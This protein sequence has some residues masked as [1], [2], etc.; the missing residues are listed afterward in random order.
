MENNVFFECCSGKAVGIVHKGIFLFVAML[1]GVFVSYAQD[2]INELDSLFFSKTEVRFSFVE[3]DLS[4]VAELAD[5]ISIDSRKQDSIYTAYANKEELAR[6]LEKGY[7]YTL[8]GA[9]LDTKSA[10][11]EEYMATTLEEMLGW[12]KYPT[13]DVYLQCMA[14]FANTYPSKCKVDTIGESVKGRLILALKISDNVLEDEDEPSF[15]YVSSMHGN[16]L[17]GCCMLLKLADTLLKNSDNDGAIQDLLATTQ[18]YINPLSNPD[19][20]YAGGNATV[21]NA[22]RYNANRVDL[23]RNFPD[24]WMTNNFTIQKENKLMMEYMKKKQFVLS[25]TLHGG[26]E[27]LNFP[28]DSYRSS[29]K[30]HADYEWW[31]SVCDRFVAECRAYDPT[32]Y[33]YDYVNGWVHGGD[34]YVV[35]KGKQDYVNYYLN[36]REITI[37]ISAVK[38][39]HPSYLDEYWHIN[40][41]ALINYIGE[42]HRGLQGV[43]LDSETLEPISATVSV[44]NHDV[45]NSFVTTLPRSGK[46]YRLIE[47]GKYT[48]AVNAEGYIATVIE[49]VEITEMQSA[50]LKVLLNKKENDGSSMQSIFPNPCQEYFYLESKDVQ[51]YK[52]E[53]LDLKGRQLAS[54]EINAKKCT[55]DVKELVSGVYF[56]KLYTTDNKEINTLT[57]IKN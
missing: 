55:V 37:E 34:W 53:I 49:D 5:I 7:S 9:A 6:F 16:E 18:I 29:Q 14:Y 57:L 39:V 40:K 36:S 42:V 44:V 13:Y 35:R 3:K 8:L 51:M 24:P 56:V 30:K 28:W 25:A 2:D 54:K 12:N 21:L 32:A 4:K 27:E 46:F 26:A 11:N 10:K 43:V 1:V 52:Y 15:F 20:T 19:G 47:P 17:T 31:K 41:N 38:T 50:E 33:T 45:D 48:I 23:N 22:T